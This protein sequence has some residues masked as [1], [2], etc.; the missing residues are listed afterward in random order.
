MRRSKGALARAERRA[1]PTI[2]YYDLDTAEQVRRLQS[3][4]PL[5]EPLGDDP[6]DEELLSAYLK[7]LDKA[8]KQRAYAVR[9]MMNRLTKK[10]MWNKYDSS[11][12]RYTNG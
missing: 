6:V 1:R 12:R 5:P 2:A 10:V 4:Y 8:E 11:G 7:K 3:Y 9:R